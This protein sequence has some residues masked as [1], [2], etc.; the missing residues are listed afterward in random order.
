MADIMDA[1]KELQ[2]DI[3]A[4]LGKPEYADLPAFA[5]LGVLAFTQALVSSSAMLD[6]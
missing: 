5:V 2:R 3:I 6:E 1:T 4:L